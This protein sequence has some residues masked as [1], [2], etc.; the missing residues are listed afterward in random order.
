MAK[1]NRM[2]WNTIFEEKQWIL[3]F[4]GEPGISLNC[5]C[6][7]GSD[8][9]LRNLQLAPSQILRGWGNSYWLGLLEIMY[10]IAQQCSCN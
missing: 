1:S 4:R 3:H 10:L 7:S 8:E 2:C 6:I 9:E 5:L